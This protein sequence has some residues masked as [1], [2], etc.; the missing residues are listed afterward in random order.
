MKQKVIGA[1]IG[2][3]KN[4]TACAVHRLMRLR[5]GHVTLLEAEF[6]PPK[7]SPQ[8]DYRHWAASR[9]VPPQ[10]STC[11]CFLI[12][13]A[14]NESNKEC[15]CFAVFILTHGSD[16]GKIFGTDQDILL[17]QLMEPLKNNQWLVGKP[18]MVFVQVCYSTGITI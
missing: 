2:P 17:S 5:L 16:S 3:S 15:D 11:S 10:T 6:Q 12:V 13:A 18:K 9:W 7:L 8:L 14:K 1:H 4:N